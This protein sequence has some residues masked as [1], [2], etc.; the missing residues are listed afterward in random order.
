[1][2]WKAGIIF[3]LMVMSNGCAPKK[4]SAPAPWPT[5]L[6][7]ACGLWT[8]PIKTF[9]MISPKI[10][11]RFAKVLLLLSGTLLT[12]PTLA[13]TA[14]PKLLGTPVQ[15]SE[16]RGRMAI[17]IDGQPYIA[18]FAYDHYQNGARNSLL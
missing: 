4:P 17:D 2:T 15:I 7:K 18:A 16:N 5:T 13:Q 3:L 14:A 11:N 9:I 8:K 12:M 10:T 6:P 1:F